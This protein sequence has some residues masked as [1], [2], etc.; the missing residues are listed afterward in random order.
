M[1]TLVR[2]LVGV[3]LVAILAAAL[4]SVRYRYDHIVVQGDTYLVRVHRITAH[5][6]ILI[7]GDGWVPAEEAWSDSQDQSPDSRT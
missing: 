3:L 7:P 4:W 6:D 5:A 2:S 1:K